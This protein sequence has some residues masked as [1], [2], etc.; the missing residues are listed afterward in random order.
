MSIPASVFQVALLPV[1][2]VVIPIIA[3]FLMLLAKTSKFR[4]FLVTAFSIL[5][6]VLS[7]GLLLLPYKPTPFLLELD[8]HLVS[9]IMMAIEIAL[10][11]YIIFI[12]IRSKKLLISL[13]ALLQTGAMVW[14]EV[15]QGH[16]LE[17]K[18]NCF[19][20]SF[21]VIM[22]LIVGIIGSLI[23]V[24]SIGYMKIF[25]EQ[26]RDEMKDKQPF[27]FFII[28]IFL[29]SMFGVVFAN[30]LTWFY[31]FWEIT[32]ICSFLL[33]GYKGNDKSKKNALKALLYNL[34]GGLCFALAIIFCFFNAHTIELN[35]LM[36]LKQSAVLLPVLLLCFAGL[37]KSAQLP[38]SSWLIGAMVAPTPV[39][40]LLHSSTM[41]KAG[42]Y[43]LIRLAGNLENTALGFTIALIGAVTFLLTSIIA[44]SQSDAKKVLAYSTI[45]NLGLIVMC[46]GMGTYEAV[47]AAVLLIIFH[48][49]AKALLFL[50]V[51]TI[52][53]KTYSR[54]IEHM[55]G[56]IVSLP[57]LSIM[58]QIGIAGMFLAPFGMLI[59]KWAVLKAIVDYNPLIAIFLVFGSA[60]TLFFWVKWMGCLICVI[61]KKEDMEDGVSR[62]EWIPLGVLSALTIGIC[63]LFPVVGNL[64]IEPFIKMMYST[65]VEMGRSSLMIM[66]IMLG[67]VMLFPLS[68]LNY[69]KRVKVVDAY[70]GGANTPTGTAFYNSFGADSDMG[71][72]SYYLKNYL[73]EKQILWA[74]II[75]CLILM[76]V[77]LLVVLV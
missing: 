28:F 9:Q 1:W 54:E 7:L 60:A 55:S 21:S 14:F 69:G 61:N 56:M 64:L 63:A 33:I 51:G 65:S 27:F 67:M 25:H 47:W 35:Q 16:S 23:A 48:A 24:Y 50:C 11:L 66:V 22:G 36:T 29:S 52:E 38:F 12:G 53:H 71:M 42:V 32:T 43:L 72:R 37:T 26:H 6:A 58:L 5:I 10:A 17:V 44:V 31:F 49:L 4:S 8:S 74:G 45:S 15:T 3:G 77:A 19:I 59:S 41:V 75:G 73:K 62:S 76:A 13:L 18:N 20:D 30:N 40:A 68:F 39:S 57:K 46:A 34:I 70:L 2:L